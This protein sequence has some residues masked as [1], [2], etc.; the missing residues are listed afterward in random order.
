MWY[1]A[2]GGNW[3]LAQFE[4]GDQLPTTVNKIKIVNTNL[5]NDLDKWMLES[6]SPLSGTVAAKSLPAFNTAYDNTIA[7]CNACH[8]NQK[9]GGVP[10]SFVKITR[11]T[12]PILSNLDYSGGQ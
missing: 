11:P 8:A 1:A 10:L 6:V 7:Q 12:T 2:Q 5:A 3:D 9:A 4:V